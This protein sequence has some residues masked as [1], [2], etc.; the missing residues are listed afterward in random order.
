VHRTAQPGDIAVLFR[1]RESHREIEEALEA[2]GIPTYVYKG[3]GFFETDEIKDL[4]ALLRYLAVPG[5]RARTAAFLRSRIVRL[6]DRGLLLLGDHLAGAPVSPALPDTWAQLDPDDQRVLTVVRASVPRW[7][8]LVDRVPPAEVLDV[9]LAE[10]GYPHE[11]RGPRQAQA[12]E[13]VK[14]LRALVR[15]IQNRGYATMERIASH[16]DRLSAGDESNAVIDAINAVNLMTVHAAKGLEF[17]VVFV[18]HLGRGSGSTAPPVRVVADAGHGEPAVTVGGFKSDADEEER[19]RDREETKR[20]LYV[21]TT[22]ARDRLYLC[23]VTPGGTFK[24]HRGSLGEVLPADVRDLFARLAEGAATVEWEGPSGRRHAL[25][26]CRPPDPRVVA[27]AT[28]GGTRAE[29]RVQEAVT[30][31]RG[32]THTTVTALVH[33]AA[34]RPFVEAG[35]R[36]DAATGR[37]VHRLFQA[38][39]ASEAPVDEL[40][41]LARRLQGRSGDGDGDVEGV[42]EEAVTT[43]LALRRDEDVR[44]LLASGDVRYEVPFSL[45]LDEGQTIVRGAIDCMVFAS[46]S[47]AVVF[48]I[49]TGRPA[50]WHQSQLDLYVVAARRL[51]PHATVSGRLVYPEGPGL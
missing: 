29:P 17:P 41:T 36:S 31:D 18:A 46:P 11:L 20:L 19:V 49:K 50:A 39:P 34:E 40:R 28:A 3:L 10:S 24:A 30:F 32:W 35:G 2:R 43:F 16:L 44:R 33:P 37:L 38:A 22:R 12:E 23:A 48:E 21:A 8:A 4:A 5:S 14:K 47:E 27:T 26:A 51:F 1:T 7:L 9:V 15:R 42:V 25:R 6:S 45:R 13:N